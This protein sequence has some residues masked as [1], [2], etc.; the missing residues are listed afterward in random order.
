MD[1]PDHTTHSSKVSE[2][3]TLSIAV[4]PLAV[5]LLAGPGTIAMAL[6]YASSDDTVSSLVA[7]AAF[8][9]LCVITYLFFISGEKITK[10]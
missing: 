1:Q 7:I 5:P 9:I 3:A 10:F 8:F 2:D 6:S 4:S